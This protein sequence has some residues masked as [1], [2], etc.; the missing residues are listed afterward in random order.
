MPSSFQCGLVST[1]AMKIPKIIANDNE[2]MN[3]GFIIKVL[4]SFKIFIGY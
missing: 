3:D 2:R 1:Y 4:G